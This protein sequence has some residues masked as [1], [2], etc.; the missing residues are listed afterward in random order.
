MA[1]YFQDDFWETVKELPD[2][3]RKEA[4]AS[5]V[6]YFFTGEE[7]DVS[8]IASMPYKA[9]KG[10]LDIAR[11][12]SKNA[13]QPRQKQ[14]ETEPE[15]EPEKGA[16]SQT[17]ASEQPN[18]SQTITKP[19]PNASQTLAK[20]GSVPAQRKSKKESSKEDSKRKAPF[21]PPSPEEVE[22][23]SQSRGHPIDG[24]AFCDYYEAVGW[25]IGRNKPMRDWQASVRTWITRDRNDQAKGGKASANVERFVGNLPF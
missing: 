7:P 1:F 6:E 21:V 17:L 25:T 18:A 22:R 9:F 12:Q 20:T 15:P 19:Q 2:Q 23:Y 14:D 24:R 10:R 13:K 8:G 3:M 16:S 4:I 11:K 5:L